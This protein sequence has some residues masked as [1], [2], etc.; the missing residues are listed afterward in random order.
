MHYTTRVCVRAP[1]L[2]GMLHALLAHLMR[3]LLWAG[4]NR[5]SSPEA[6]SPHG[7]FQGAVEFAVGVHPPVCVSMRVCM[8]TLFLVAS[9]SVVPFVRWE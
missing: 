3:P 1:V 9:F 2:T 4:K 8:G 7:G 5:F 6:W